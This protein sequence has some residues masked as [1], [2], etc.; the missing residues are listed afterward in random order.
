MISPA[1]GESEYTMGDHKD[2]VVI[3][4]LQ[5]LRGESKIKARH[6]LLIFNSVDLKMTSIVINY[7]EFDTGHPIKWSDYISL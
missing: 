5:T 6:I 4:S 7:P 3:S 1:G 2:F